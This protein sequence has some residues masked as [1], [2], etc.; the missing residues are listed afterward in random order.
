MFCNNTIA[1]FDRET[2]SVGKLRHISANIS[3]IA[4]TN[5]LSVQSLLNEHRP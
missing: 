1:E 3:I 5:Q 2:F 4:V